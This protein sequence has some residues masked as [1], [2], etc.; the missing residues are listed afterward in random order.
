MD[1]SGKRPLISFLDKRISGYESKRL[2]LAGLVVPLALILI[3]KGLT[4][5]SHEQILKIWWGWS[6]VGAGT[7]I[8]M[9]WSFSPRIFPNGK[10][11][12]MIKDELERYQ[13]IEDSRHRFDRLLDYLKCFPLGN[14]RLIQPARRA[15]GQLH[16][17]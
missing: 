12:R 10:H 1:T 6:I 17:P 14:I 7:I 2:L 3:M 4:G 11:F 15:N 13:R 8:A 16:G 5:L 9:L